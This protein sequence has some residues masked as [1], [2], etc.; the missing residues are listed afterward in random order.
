MR[1]ALHCGDC[2]DVLPG[3]P[4]SHACVTDPPYGLGFMGKDWDHGVPGAHFWEV[5]RAALLP[6]APVLAFG[7]TRTHHRLMVAMEDAGL[8]IRDTIMWVYGSGFPKS[9]DVGKAID[10]AAGA[11]REVVGPAPWLGRDPRGKQPHTSVFTDDSWTGRPDSERGITAPATDAARAW[12]GWGTALKPA[13]EPIVVA[14]VPLDGTVAH[15]VQTH[16]TGAL[17]IEASRVPGGETVG[18]SGR[19]GFQ[20]S[21]GWNANSVESRTQSTYEHN[22]GRFPANLIHDGSEEVVRLFPTEAGAASPVRGDAPSRPAKNTYGE[23]GRKGF[24]FHGDTGSAARFFYCAKASPSDRGEGNTHPTVKPL[25]L[26][27]YLVRLVTPPGGVVL[28]PFA[29]SGSTLVAAQSLGIRSVG[30]ELDPAHCRI[31]ERR[32]GDQESLELGAA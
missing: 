12:D 14:R 8:E 20:Q 22:K 23:Y 32:F 5:I 10:K 26:M 31:A 3:L 4:L 25:E 17:N 21:S 9:L 28:D 19:W 7:G 2:R 18:A 6:G 27:R 11:A 24:G 15:N 16:G 30:V 13:W 1:V 29:G